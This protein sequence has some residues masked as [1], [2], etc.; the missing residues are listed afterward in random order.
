MIHGI[1]ESILFARA[2]SKAA[3]LCGLANMREEADGPEGLPGRS[4]DPA[5]LV[6][7]TSNKEGERNG[8]EKERRYRAMK[9]TSLRQQKRNKTV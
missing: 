7:L 8:E 5:P 9:N 1:V 3:A 4:V 6:F 2:N